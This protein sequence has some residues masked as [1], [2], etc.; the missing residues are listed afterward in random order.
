MARIGVPDDVGVIR[1]AIA[2][3]KIS[4]L[5]RHQPCRVSRHE[6][7]HGGGGGRTV[8]PGRGIAQG[9]PGKA[10]RRGGSSGPGGPLDSRLNLDTLDPSNKKGVIS[11]I[12][13]GSPSSNWRQPGC[14]ASLRPRTEP[15]VELH[16][17]FRRTHAQP[18][19]SVAAARRE[20]LEAA[21]LH[22]VDALPF[23]TLRRLPAKAWPPLD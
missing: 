18:P 1:E 15:L 17:Q 2:E 20:V 4:H 14:S 3:R 10:R 19:H 7:T 13:C 12:W 22:C 23:R 21:P 8:G 5:H 6:R 9:G 16:Q 11:G